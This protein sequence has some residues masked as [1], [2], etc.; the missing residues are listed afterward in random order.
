[1]AVVVVAEA[2]FHRCSSAR[3][4]SRRKEREREREGEIV[5]IKRVW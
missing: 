3:V 1:M 5:R 4:M 2:V